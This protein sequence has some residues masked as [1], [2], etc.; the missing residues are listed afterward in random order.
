[1]DINWTDEVPGSAQ[2]TPVNRL[3][4]MG[5]Q[6][7]FPGTTTITH[8]DAN[9][10]QIVE[11]STEGTTTTRIVKSGTT[12]TITRT[13]VAANNGPTITKTITITKSGTTTTI[14][15]SVVTS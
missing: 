10:T 14:G 15:E 8:P 5:M 3:R 4:L 9:T 11:T 7:Y 13:F 2:G 1:M 6:G 12:R